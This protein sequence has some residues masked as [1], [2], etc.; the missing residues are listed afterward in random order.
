[1]LSC[2]TVTLVKFGFFG[3]A[4][5]Q[6]SAQYIQTVN[7]INILFNDSDFTKMTDA[8]HSNIYDY[9]K[10][11]STNIPVN[12]CSSLDCILCFRDIS[13]DSFIYMFQAWSSSCSVTAEKKTSPIVSSTRNTNAERRKSR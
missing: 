5:W 13:L 9:L 12:I 3:Q 4:S 6:S 7:I 8:I 1:M 11:I 2:L 10:T